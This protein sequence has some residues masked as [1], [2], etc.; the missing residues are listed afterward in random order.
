MR[1]RRAVRRTPRQQ[2]FLSVTVACVC[3]R[4]CRGGSGDGDD[5]PTRVPARRSSDARARRRRLS[6]DDGDRDPAGAGCVAAALVH[7]RVHRRQGQGL[8][9][10][11]ASAQQHSE[12]TQPGRQPVVSLMRRDVVVRE[13]G[14]TPFRQ[15]FWSRNGAPANIVGHRWDA[16]TEA[17]RQITL[18]SLG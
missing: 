15:I 2:S 5:G 13:R 4:A 17:F 1:F 10:D 12:Q 3:A 11:R 7:L 6:R 14:G 16:N 18:Y 8:S 9:P